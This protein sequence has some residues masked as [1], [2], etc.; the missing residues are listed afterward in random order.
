M[1]DETDMNE[2]QAEVGDVPDLDPAER[3]EQSLEQLEEDG[4]LDS[5]RITF[6]ATTVSGVSLNEIRDI[7]YRVGFD[8]YPVTVTIDHDGDGA[9]KAS[10]DYGDGE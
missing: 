7:L 10:F 9:Y 2:Q 8:D 1:A 3:L 4:E 5:E 6:R